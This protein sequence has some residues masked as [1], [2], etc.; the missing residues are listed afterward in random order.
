M[1]VVPLTVRLPAIVTWPSATVNSVEPA[2]SVRITPPA[3]VNLILPWPPASWISASSA[4]LTIDLLP[5]DAISIFPPPTYKSLAIPTPPSTLKAPVVALV[6]S[7]VFLIW[8][9]P[10]LAAPIVIAV[11]EPAIVA[12][13]TAPPRFK[14]VTLVF[15]K[16][17][18]PLTVDDIVL[19]FTPKV[20][21][22]VVLPV[23][24]TLNIL[25]VLSELS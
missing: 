11:P 15:N 20:P 17:K 18:A 6:L 22:I 13:V 24:S 8:T 2:L 5:S 7:L 12:V 14:V 9:W 19:P 25:V 16:L 10:A 1:V 3:S 21:A 23:F 4:I